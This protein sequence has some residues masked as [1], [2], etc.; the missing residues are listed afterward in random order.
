MVPWDK[1]RCLSVLSG[2]CELWHAL[3]LQEQGSSEAFFEQHHP[4]LEEN[5]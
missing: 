2:L 1:P 5:T 4:F 3:Q